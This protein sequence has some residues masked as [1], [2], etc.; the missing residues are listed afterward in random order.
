MEQPSVTH[1]TLK[2][3]PMSQSSASKRL[4]DLWGELRDLNAAAA[5]LEWDQETQMRSAGHAQRGEVLAT[6]AGTIHRLLTAPELADVLARCGDEAEAGSELAGQVAAA[7]REVDRAVKVPERLTREL[8]A[9]RAASLEAWQKAREKADFS[10]YAEVLDTMIRLR[11]EEAEAIGGAATTYDVHLDRFEPGTTSAMVEPL[12]QELVTALRPLVQQVAESQVNIDESPALG[13]FA[14]DGQVA[15]GRRL[16]EA[17]GFDFNAGRLDPSTHPFCVAIHRNDVRMTYRY[18]EKDFRPF[19][20]GIL[21]ETGHGLYEQGLP[22]RWHK[23]PLDEAASLSIHESQS[24]LWENHVGRSRGFWRWALPIFKEHFPSTDME[25][26]SLWPTLHVVRPSLIRVDADEVTYHLHIAVRFDIERRLFAGELA[27]EDLPEAWDALY[28]SYL[29]VRPPNT[30]QGVLQDVHWSHGSF[31][32]FP[33]YTLG[34]MVSAQLFAAASRDLGDLEEAFA[35]GEFGVLLDWLRRHV[36][37]HARRLTPSEIV[38]GATGK[39]L[40]IDD[41]VAYLRGKTEEIYAA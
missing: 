11:R 9:T 20:F 37:D 3:R 40:A 8:A 35:Q 16:A 28:E 15:F 36:H 1:D 38:E 34:S 26:E 32:Y 41:L 13:Q 21:H 22:D 18:D 39:P 23:T 14:G 31:G 12:M 30:A 24:R 33:T 25:L 6:L 2:E 10:L 5:L 29:G 19:L 17:I 4:F 7:R 27:T